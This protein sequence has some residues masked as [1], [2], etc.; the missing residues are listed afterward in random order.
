[1]FLLSA[2]LNG[3][4]NANVLTVIHTNVMSGAFIKDK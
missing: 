3:K 1:M 2:T 4:W